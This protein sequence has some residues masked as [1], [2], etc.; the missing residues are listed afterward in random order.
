LYKKR[1]FRPVSNLDP[2]LGIQIRIQ[3]RDLIPDLNPDSDPDLNPDPD[4]KL[5]AGRIRIG[6]RIRNFCCVSATLVADS[7]PDHFGK[8]DPDP[9]ECEILGL[10]RIR[11]KVKGGS[12]IHIR[13]KVR[14]RIR[15]KSKS[16]IRIC[17]SNDII[18]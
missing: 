4:S 16:G 2:E 3:I 14:S 8:A 9:L 5:T 15:I 6:N 10:M 1:K 17:I 18:S 11:F 7:H 13:L 12:L